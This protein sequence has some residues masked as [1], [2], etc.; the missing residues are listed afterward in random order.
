MPAPL[1]AALLWKV[2]LLRIE[3]LLPDTTSALP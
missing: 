1:A 2:L 3:V